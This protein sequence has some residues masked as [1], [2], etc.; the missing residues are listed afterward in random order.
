MRKLWLA[1]AMILAYPAFG[2]GLSVYERAAAA[3]QSGQFSE[4][5]RML[6]PILQQ[7]GRDLRALTLTGMAVSATGRLEEGNRSY[8]QALEVNPSFAP[9]LRNLAANEM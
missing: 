1:A 3:I 6:E 8:R 5:V 4:A 2:Q 7:D 9:A